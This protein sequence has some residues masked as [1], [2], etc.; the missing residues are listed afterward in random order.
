MST[1]HHY[2]GLQLITIHTDQSA[3]QSSSRRQGSPP[4]IPAPHQCQLCRHTLPARRPVSLCEYCENGLPWLAPGC[5]RCGLATAMVVPGERQC[6]VCAMDPPPYRCCHGL[7]EFTAPADRMIRQFKDREDFVAGHALARLLAE[8]FVRHYQ[9]ARH[10]LP[11]ALIPVPLSAHR[12][13]QRGFN[14]SVVLARAVSR[15]S[16]IPVRDDV[17]RRPRP[18]TDQRGLDRAARQR[19]MREAFTPSPRR[20]LTVPEHVAIIDDVVTTGATAAALAR[21]LHRLEA[22]IVDVWCLARVEPPD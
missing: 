19:N 17:C 11:S 18:T 1:W 10:P 15:Y 21:L 9:E 13:C 12:L 7:F 5:P 22:R 16:G 8:Q 20:R 3:A 6:A 4:V 14:Q 2:T